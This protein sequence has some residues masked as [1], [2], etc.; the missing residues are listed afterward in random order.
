MIIK[1]SCTG[2]GSHPDN[3]GCSL[4][5]ASTQREC[6][7][8]FSH[9]RGGQRL[10]QF[11]RL[12]DADRIPDIRLKGLKYCNFS[13]NWRQKTRPKH[14]QILIVSDT[15]FKW[16]QFSRFKKNDQYIYIDKLNVLRYKCLNSGKGG[17]RN[18]MCAWQTVMVCQSHGPLCTRNSPPPTTP[19]TP[20]HMFLS[21]PNT[22]DHVT[23]KS[24]IRQ[25]HSQS[26]N[27]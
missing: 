21:A 10:S 5:Y 20:P 27:L 9:A 25:S 1:T 23:I 7:R 4:I 24:V 3:R 13:N 26:L 12:A 11:G 2:H 14:Q 15:A 17:E 16:S 6:R 8:S 19:V 18:R 22:Q